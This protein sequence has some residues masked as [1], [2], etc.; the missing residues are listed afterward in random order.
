[1]L[2]RSSELIS[3]FFAQ[4]MHSQRGRTNSSTPPSSLRVEHEPGLYE[5]VRNSA[6]AAYADSTGP[7]NEKVC[8]F[9]FGFRMLDFVNVRRK[10]KK[11]V[12][13]FQYDYNSH[14]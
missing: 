9:V 5:P 11:T 3:S 6:S 14:Y 1:M 13:I 8:G 7:R 4:E 2:G 10:Q 12:C